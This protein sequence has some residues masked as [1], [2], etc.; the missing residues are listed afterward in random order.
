[1]YLLKNKKCYWISIEGTDGTGKTT[2]SKK[3]FNYLVKKYPQKKF[4]FLNEFS[5]SKL[6][7]LVKSIIKSE[8]FFSLGKGRHYPISE[9]LVL[10]ADIA[11]QL[12]K[13][14]LRKNRKKD[15]HIVSDRGIATFL[16]YQA[17]RLGK[18]YGEN[19]ILMENLKRIVDLIGHPD[20]SICLVSSMNFIKKRL[21]NK[22]DNISTKNLKFISDVQNEYISIFEKNKNKKHLIL[23]NNT[24]SMKETA[25][26]LFANV[27]RFIGKKN[28]G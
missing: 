17:L 14:I 23:E 16:A 4:I 25:L 24:G 19:K 20:I 7:N 5:D 9:T 21:K 28:S 13:N 8:T 6:G 15:I 2:L 11:L 12:E 3:L 18:A 1:M 10:L 27:D 26:K 22:G